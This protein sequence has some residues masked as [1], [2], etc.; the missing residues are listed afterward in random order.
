MKNDKR[1]GYGILYCSDGN[2]YEGEWKNN[3]SYN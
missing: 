2:K 3:N 1:E